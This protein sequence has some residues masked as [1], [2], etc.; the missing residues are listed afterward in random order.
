MGHR[1]GTVAVVGRP[2]VGK[3]TIINALVGQKVSII[4]DKPQTTRNR[5]LGIATDPDWQ[6][7]FVDTPGIHKPKHR[8]G[9]ALNDVAKQSMSGVDALLMVVD[10]S[11]APGPGDRMI[12]DWTLQ[13][14]GEIGITPRRIL[15]L[16]KMDL[17]KAKDVEARYESYQ[18]M[19]QPDEIMMTSCTRVQNLD[20]LTGLL[21][22]SLPEG[23]P[24]YDDDSVTD[25]SVQFLAA[26]MVREKLLHATR[27]ELPHAISTYVES[28]EEEDGLVDISVVIL[29]ERDSQKAI[30][31]GK[32]GQ[33]LKKVGSLARIEIEEMID[34]KVF[35][36][37]FVK[38]RTDWRQNPRILKELGYL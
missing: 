18:A 30:V 4:S 26:E 14:D 13:S 23:E 1:S 28:W 37:L 25:Q 3:S 19:F 36:S 11:R 35:L 16:N 21:V 7:V 2:N 17:L 10:I 27:E 34:C 6:I 31:I 38:V 12:A 24:L 33:M 15:C 29:V 5:L 8:L 32:K 22:A 20:L 9:R